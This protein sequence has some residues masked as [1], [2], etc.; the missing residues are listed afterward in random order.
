MQLMVGQL[1]KSTARSHTGAVEFVIRIVHLV[2][3]E[4]GLQAALIESLVM[5]HEGQA[6]NQRLYLFPYLRE[7]RRLLR[8]LATET[9]DLAA[10]EIIVVGLRLYQGIERV[11]NLTTPDD[12]HTY[13]ADTGTLVVGRLEID[14]CKVIHYLSALYL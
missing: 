10:P 6:L 9:V 2:T 14:C 13:R 12:H 3:T 1:W 4:D 11:H 8:I 5:G 7:D